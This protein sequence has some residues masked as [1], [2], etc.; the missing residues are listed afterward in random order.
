MIIKMRVA[1][2]IFLFYFFIFISNIKCLFIPKMHLTKYFQ[3]SHASDQLS[4]HHD[5]GK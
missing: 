5:L 1:S 4:F 2:C 3:L